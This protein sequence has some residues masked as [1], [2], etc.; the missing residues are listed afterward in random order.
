MAVRTIRFAG[1]LYDPKPLSFAGSLKVLNWDFDFSNFLEQEKLM[2]TQL[3][4]S[5]RR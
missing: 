5:K 3:H 1:G 4:R 2:E